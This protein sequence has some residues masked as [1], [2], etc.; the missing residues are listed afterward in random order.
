MQRK[1]RKRMSKKMKWL[2]AILLLA[3][4]AFCVWFFVIRDKDDAGKPVDMTDVVVRQNLDTTYNTSGT[5]ALKNQKA[6]NAMT[7]ASASY[8]VKEVNVKPRSP[9]R[10]AA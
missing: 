10:W 4:A 6:E 7:D 9:T 8:R 2:I 5:L 1:E 3:A